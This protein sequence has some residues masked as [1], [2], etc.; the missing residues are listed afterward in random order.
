MTT[1]V[2]K[3]CIITGLQKIC[4]NITITP[5]NSEGDDMAI[6][7]S[8]LSNEGRNTFENDSKTTVIV[9]ASG[10]DMS[11]LYADGQ[12]KLLALNVYSF[13]LSFFCSRP[14]TI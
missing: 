5:A 3:Q 2:E 1:S 7:G 10:P 4:D 8:L 11:E 6:S 14:D 9:P 13:F 12:I